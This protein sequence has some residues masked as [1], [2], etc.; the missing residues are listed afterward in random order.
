MV[1]ML[2]LMRSGLSLGVAVPVCRGKDTEG[3]GDTGLKVQVDGLRERERI[4]SYNLP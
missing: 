3:D 2:L 4:F 1:M